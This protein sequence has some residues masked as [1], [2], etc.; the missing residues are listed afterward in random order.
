MKKIVF[1]CESYFQFIVAVNL[2]LTLYDNYNADLIM[3]D[4][5]Q[6][7]SDVCDRIRNTSVFD[8]VIL[9]TTPLLYSGNAYTKLQKLRKCFKY[10]SVEIK[11]EPYIK[12]IMPDIDFNYDIVFFNGYGAL[13]DAVFNT[14]KRTNN[15]VICYRFEESFTNYFR[16]YVHEKSKKRLIIESFFARIFGNYNIDDFVA[17]CYYFEPSLLQFK[18]QNY[19]VI[20]MPKISRNNRLLVNTIN[21]AFGYSEMKDS[22]SEKFI[23]F[24]DGSAFW[25]GEREDID[26]FMD[27]A[28]IVGND[29][30]FIK[31]HPRTTDNR[32][33]K[34]GINTNK[35]VGIPWECILLNIEMK[36]K[37]FIASTSSAA[38]SSHIYFGDDCVSIML[39]DCYNKTPELVD[40]GFRSYVKAFK[41][42]FG[43]D[44][45]IV[46]KNKQELIDAINSLK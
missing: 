36:N 19:K 29:S 3:Y 1:I 28:K 9:V 31:L 22:Y 20:Q 12:K 4:T 25:K 42:R 32:F 24:E 26:F 23:A 13:T 46:P 37:V 44:K 21:T 41:N 45:L 8:K 34:S 16:E 38:I 7:V 10:I 43:N 40:E 39:Y 2:K 11:A 6:G 30:F 5:S 15:N 33:V 14:I 17:G 27:I 18:P 35:T